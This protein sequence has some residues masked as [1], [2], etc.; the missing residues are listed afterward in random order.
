MHYK[1][2]LIPLLQEAIYRMHKCD[3]IH[4]E[5]VYV[6]EKFQGQT[7]WC[8]VV[9]VF[10]VRNH[11]KSKRCFAWLHREE[12]KSPRQVALLETWLVTSPE[13][14]VKAA[15]ALDIALKKGGTHSTDLNAG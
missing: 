8:G 10:D 5:S 15:I 2:G 6:D 4:R 13:T 14:A 11:P 12:G 7:I 9:E 1:S 3:A